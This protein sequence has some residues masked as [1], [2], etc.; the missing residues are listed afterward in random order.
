[1]NKLLVLQTA[2]DLVSSNPCNLVAVLSGN[3]T[4]CVMRDIDLP[5]AILDR[6]AAVTQLAAACCCHEAHSACGHLRVRTYIF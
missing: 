4:D 5:A 1:M 3:Y 6:A 2:S